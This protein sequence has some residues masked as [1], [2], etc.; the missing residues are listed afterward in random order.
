MRV[1]LLLLGL[2]GFVN[3]RAQLE[4]AGGPFGASILRM[5]HGDSATYVTTLRGVY[6]TKDQGENWQRLI[7]IPISSNLYNPQPFG[8]TN[9]WPLAAR[10]S[11][12]IVWYFGDGKSHLRYSGD[13][14]MTWKEPVLPQYKGKLIKGDFVIG[15]S[16][17]YMYKDSLLFYSGN[18]KYWNLKILPTDILGVQSDQDHWH[19]WTSDSI[20]RC[21]QFPDSWVSYPMEIPDL[22]PGTL[23]I[24][25]GVIFAISDEPWPVP[26]SFWVAPCFGCGFE[27]KPELSGVESFDVSVIAD[28]VFL[29]PKVWPG[30]SMW[31]AGLDVDEFVR[32]SLRT[33]PFAYPG[34]TW[35]DATLE[36]DGSSLFITTSNRFDYPTQ[37]EPR[38]SKALLRS[39]DHGF[40]WVVKE[41]GIDE[42]WINGTMMD[43]SGVYV[44]TG[45]GLFF[46]PAGSDSWSVLGPKEWYTESVAWFD[47]KLWRVSSGPN[48]IHVYRS[49]DQGITWDLDMMNVSGVFTSTSGALFLK[50]MFGTV[51]R[52]KAGEANW[53]DITSSLPIS[54]SFFQLVEYQGSVIC[55]LGDD[56]YRSVD[57]GDSWEKISLPTTWW[58]HPNRLLSIHDTLYYI[59][60][61]SILNDTVQY[62]IYRWQESNSTWDLVSNSLIL[63]DENEFEISS[64]KISGL[65]IQDNQWVLGIRG[66][67]IFYSPDYGGTWTRLE[68]EDVGISTYSLGIVND[69]F[70]N[71][72]QLFGAWRM[73]LTTSACCAPPQ[74][75]HVKVFPNPTNGQIMIEAEGFKRLILF[76]AMGRMLMDQHLTDSKLDISE[77]PNGTYFIR[78]MDHQGRSILKPIIKL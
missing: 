4:Y 70:Y 7:D 54:N 50:E 1:W 15:D 55:Y 78:L 51:Y 26:N 64:W 37:D 46:Q 30:K 73:E 61:F 22:I 68:P 3:L 74:D 59:G 42:P 29:W 43:S 27:E 25:E 6:R 52:K 65:A 24:E 10:D 19:Y 39:D 20:Y 38:N 13:F 77:V 11:Q 56:V 71:V 36:T 62:R 49:A 23:R 57:A 53:A 14:G 31:L 69:W 16:L 60:T 66:K 12:V 44:C 2:F 48:G 18:K 28:S 35:G 45:N 32:D 41:E 76:D 34:L 72:S 8:F 67:G 17:I 21:L 75:E 40:T 5:A 58:D 33:T 47:G 63:S 9:D